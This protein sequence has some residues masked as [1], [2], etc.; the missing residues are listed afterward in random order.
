VTPAQLERWQRSRALDE[1]RLEVILLQVHECRAVVSL[2]GQEVELIGELVAL[3]DLADLPA[4]ALRGDRLAA[5]E[6]VEDL[7]RALRVADR[8]R[9][10]ADGVVVVEQQDGLPA[11]RKI[12]RGGQSHR[13]RAHDDHAAMATRPSSSAG[14]RYS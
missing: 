6:A 10:D 1:A 9:A 3:V 11:A 8:A 13:P 4:H 2:F 7:E 5:S 12:D 14:L